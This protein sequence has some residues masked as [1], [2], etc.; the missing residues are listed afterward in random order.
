MKVL[1]AVVAALSTGLLGLFAFALN[2]W[3]GGSFSMGLESWIA[4][5]A[6][7]L[8]QLA[9]TIHLARAALSRRG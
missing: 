7:V 4:F 5:V 2:P 1:F 6:L 8:G 9:V 3:T